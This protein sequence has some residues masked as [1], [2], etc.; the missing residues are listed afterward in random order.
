MSLGVWVGTGSRDEHPRISGSSH[1]LE[2]L[3]FKGTPDRSALEIAAAFEAV[4]GD[5]NAFT[6]REMTCFYARFLDKDLGM[7]V[8]HMCD[9]VQNSLLRRPDFESEKQVILEEINMYEDSPDDLIH[10]RPWGRGNNPK[11]AVR[12]FLKSSD[13]F[14]VDADIEHK[15]LITVAPGGYLKCLRD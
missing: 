15:L 12:E 11:T 13:R 8:E 5:L 9:M 7:A 10:D 3:L 6:D 2:H 1:F 14:A 4:G